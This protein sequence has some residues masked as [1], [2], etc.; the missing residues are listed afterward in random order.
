MASGDAIL[1]QVGCAADADT[2]DGDFPIAFKLTWT[3]ANATKDIESNVTVVVG[4]GAGTDNFPCE[5]MVMVGSVS[6][7]AFVMA[8]GGGRIGRKR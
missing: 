2:P 4:Q 6:V 7:L 8:V 5:S 3:E 1:F